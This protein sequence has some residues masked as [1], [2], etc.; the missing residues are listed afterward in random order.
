[1]SGISSKLGYGIPSD[2]SVVVNRTTKVCDVFGVNNT[3]ASVTGDTYSDGQIITCTFPTGTDY[4]D[5]RRS[6]LTFEVA[7]TLADDTRWTFG[8]HGSGC[9]FFKSIAIFARSGEELCRTE[10]FNLLK[11]MM[12]Q[13]QYS[14]QWFQ[15]Q[16][17]GMWYGSKIFNSP[18][19]FV[20]PMYILSPLFSYGKLLPAALVSGMRIELTLEQHE[21]V[22]FGVSY[23][24]PVV[25][26][27]DATT[28]S[29][30]E[31]KFHLEM[32]KLGD[33]IRMAM[34][35]VLATKG[36][37]MV[38][39]GWHHTSL[40]SES[41]MTYT[42]SVSITDSFTRG[43]RAFARVRALRSNES[44]P[45]NK[46][47]LESERDSFRGEHV[48]PY[49]TYQWRHGE[50]YYPDKP[51]AS[52]GS[53]SIIKSMNHMLNAVNQ[54]DGDREQSYAC[55]LGDYNMSEITEDLLGGNLDAGSGVQ[56][57]FWYPTF[58]GKLGCY[59][60]DAHVIG[61]DLTRDSDVKISGRPI[62]NIEPL[63][64][65]FTCNPFSEE[66]SDA[67]GKIAKVT[68]PRIVDVFLQYVKLV[69]VFLNNVQIEK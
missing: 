41:G 32:V 28:Y 56:F 49:H 51:N 24:D 53:R 54:F 40:R 20:I 52:N 30:S 46:I 58:P 9:N 29:I 55:L 22:T 50:R 67:G 7:S 25:L 6:F 31:V 37:E 45:A 57:T 44:D 68:V 21:K 18:Q 43:L 42:T 17:A 36:I 47:P 66:E 69:R 63:T 34:D 65:N 26:P 39:T 23:I 27:E 59:A 60:R 33:N 10:D 5:T 1:M 19:T 8:V 16:G 64:L 3:G 12:L 35:E 38:Y 61:V 13:F 15:R 11:N 2:T 14:R 48:F 62:N 4:V